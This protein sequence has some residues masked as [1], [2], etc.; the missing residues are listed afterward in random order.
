MRAYLD[1][2]RTIEST[3]GALHPHPQRLLTGSHPWLW[4][5]IT[6]SVNEIHPA[7]L[8]YQYKHLRLL[9]YHLLYPLRRSVLRMLPSQRL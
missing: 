1:N 2:P 8:L 4:L 7:K 5:Q 3:C 9:V 6:H